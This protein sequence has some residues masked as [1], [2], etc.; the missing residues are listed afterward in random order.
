M[1]IFVYYNILKKY[2]I[3]K[4]NIIYKINP[5]LKGKKCKVAFFD[6][7]HTLIKPLQ[8]RVHAKS[9]E[10]VTLWHP[11][12][13]EKLIEL[14]QNKYKIVIITNQSNLL[15]EEKKMN[16]FKGKI[17]FL[18]KNLFYDKF[19]ILASL[20]KD[21]A[22]KP[23]L[24][25]YDFLKEKTKVNID[26]SQ[27]FMVGDAAGRTAIKKGILSSTSEAKKKDFS[28]ADRM[29][30]ANLGI[31]FMTP[32]E[33]FLGEE[34]RKFEMERLSHKLFSNVENDKKKLDT[35]LEKI[36]K[37]SVIM[38]HGPPA[39]GKST[40][41]KMLELEEYQIINQD[42]LGTKGKCVN[43]MKKLLEKD[44]SQKI[45]LDNTNGKISY[46]SSFTN[47]LNTMKL[48]Y[49]LVSIDVNKEQSFFLNNFR[50]KLE[51]KERLSDI[52]IHSYFKYH[53]EPQLTE[54]FDKI[55][56]VPLV[57]EFNSLDEITLF[58]QYY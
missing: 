39:S 31:K 22:R 47:Y 48:K 25:L 38:L 49:C 15:D 29:W 41:A 13:P 36:K 12:V 44:P 20:K 19:N 8:G 42:I 53:D 27:S 2:M 5:S 16:I 54:G 50:C 1:I 58:N 37:Y 11:S 26:L 23:N 30:A 55:F 32:D 21:Y 14:Y 4:D 51:K 34:P 56:K 10:D 7:D 52:V 45:V 46:R 43:L 3:V 9:P 24:G 33:F 6:L 18:K 35:I 40:L 28:C 17:E 57:A